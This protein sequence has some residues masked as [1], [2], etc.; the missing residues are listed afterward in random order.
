MNIVINS[1]EHLGLAALQHNLKS[2]FNANLTMNK[3][4]TST[5]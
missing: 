4:G 1:P 5:L 2:Y 3:L